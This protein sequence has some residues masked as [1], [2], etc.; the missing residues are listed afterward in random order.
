MI[1]NTGEVCEPRRRGSARTLRKADPPSSQA[2]SCH[3]T[4]THTYRAREQVGFK[5]NKLPKY[6]SEK[7]FEKSSI[8]NRYNDNNTKRNRGEI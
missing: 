8:G 2:Y 1:N 6:G 5:R 7:A 3:S 4:L